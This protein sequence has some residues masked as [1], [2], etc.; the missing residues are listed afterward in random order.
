MGEIGLP[1][2]IQVNR[3]HHCDE[4]WTTSPSRF[5]H[6]MV[7]GTEQDLQVARRDGLN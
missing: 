2:L 7:R 1:T 5:P 6:M 3:D 4:F